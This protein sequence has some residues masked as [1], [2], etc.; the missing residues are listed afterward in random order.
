MWQAAHVASPVLLFKFASRC[1][2]EYPSDR[3]SPLI[4]QGSC[5][6]SRKRLKSFVSQT[7]A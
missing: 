7:S 5:R 1:G 3:V 6:L 2:G 4:V